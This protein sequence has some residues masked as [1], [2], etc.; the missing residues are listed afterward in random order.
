MTGSRANRPGG[1]AEH[2]L[3]QVR[4]LIHSGER[5]EAEDLLESIDADALEDPEQRYL[6][7]LAWLELEQFE[8]AAAALRSAAKA[9][10]GNAAVWNDLGCVLSQL[11]DQSGALDAWRRAARSRPVFPPALYNH[12]LALE[13]C[14]RLDEARNE[15]N[16]ALSAAP[17]AVPL[18]A[19]LGR[20]CARMQDTDAALECFRRVLEQEPDHFDAAFGAACIDLDGARFEQAAA[21]FT[22]CL[23][24]EPDNVQARLN[25]ALSLQELGRMD[26]ALIEYREV[27][28]GDP[29]RYYN[30]VKTMLSAAHGVF[31]LDSKELR[32]RLMPR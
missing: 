29:K 19:V 27:L 5:R 21:G 31:W 8:T 1:R 4:A 25:L 20:I 32:R 23:D 10:P 6:F 22:R 2:K 30:V 16:S 17:D 11:G 12:A 26:D 9:A 3:G 15:L 13:A 24:N 28:R 7:A 14:G 18:V